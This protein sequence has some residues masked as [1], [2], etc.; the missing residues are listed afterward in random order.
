MAKRIVFQEFKSVL[1][2]AHLLIQSCHFF[3]ISSAFIRFLMFLSVIVPILEWNVPLIPP[4][5]LTRSLIFPILLFSSISLHCSLKMAF[6]ISPCY[7]LE[8]CIQ[9]G[10][11]FPFS[12]AFLLIFFPQ[13]FVK[14][15]QTTTL[16]SC[17]S[18]SLG[19]FWSL[20]PV[21]CYEPLSIVF[22]VLCLPDQILWIYLS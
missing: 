4:M 10:K 2:S 3:L 13:L 18:F 7:S 16:P 17:I 12:F 20:P 15:P 9:L 8:F 19:W 5:F 6:L 14:H 11:S 22:Q 21:Q 1:I